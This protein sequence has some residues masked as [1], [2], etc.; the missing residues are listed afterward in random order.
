M[1]TYSIEFIHAVKHT[2]SKG[3][4]NT[5]ILNFVFHPEVLSKAL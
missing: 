2:R 3:K 5:V 1:F 4:I